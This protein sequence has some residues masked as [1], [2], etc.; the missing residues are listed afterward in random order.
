MAKNILVTGASRGIGEQSVYALTHTMKPEEDGATIDFE[1]EPTDVVMTYLKYRDRAEK[2]AA[3]ARESGQQVVVAQMDITNPYSVVDFA[4]SLKG[5]G[6]ELDGA[7]FNVAGGLEGDGD[8]LAFSERINH[9]GQVMLLG[10]LEPVLAEGPVITGVQSHWGELADEVQPPPF[11]GY[12]TFV[13]E[14]KQRG[15]R[16]L[17]QQVESI[18]GAVFNVVTGGIVEDTPVGRRGLRNFPEWGARQRAIG[19]VIKARDMGI[20]NARAVTNP[21]SD[22]VVWVGAT[23]ADFRALSQELKAEAE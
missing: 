4:R 3:A 13:A 16:S 7:V 20:A 15:E 19:N 8:D 1:F 10:A 2:I 21:D 23:E 5:Q 14:P 17:K 12:G 11:E 18:E 22:S 6:I 9:F